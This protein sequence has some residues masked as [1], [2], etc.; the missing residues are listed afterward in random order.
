MNLNM[1]RHIF[2]LTTTA[3]LVVTGLLK[4]LSFTSHSVLLELSDPVFDPLRVKYVL[5]LAGSIEIILAVIIWHFRRNPISIV[6]LSTLVLCFIFYRAGLL[7]LGSTSPCNCLGAPAR[8]QIADPIT[9]NRAADIILAYWIVGIVI[10]IYKS[11]TRPKCLLTAILFTIVVLPHSVMASENTI[12]ITGQIEYTQYDEKG[13]T[14]TNRLRH[15][16]HYI[17]LLSLDTPAW[18]ITALYGTN[19]SR[20]DWRSDVFGYGSNVYDVLYDPSVP[21]Q[22][23][24]PGF[25][26]RGYYPSKE[27]FRITIPWLT[28]CS[29]RH[30][31]LNIPLPWKDDFTDPVASI[32]DSKITLA[33]GSLAFP[34]AISWII[35]SKKLRSC[36]NQETLKHEGL[37]Q[38]DRIARLID[39]STI[40][41]DGIVIGE[42]RVTDWTKARG[43]T[44]PLHFMLTAYAPYENVAS[45]QL[46]NNIVNISYAPTETMYRSLLFEGSTTQIFFTNTTVQPLSVPGILSVGDYRLFNRKLNIDYVQYACTDGKWKTNIDPQLLALLDIRIDVA[47]NKIRR[48]HARQYIIWLCMALSCVIPYVG[49]RMTKRLRTQKQQQSSRNNVL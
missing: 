44:I 42:Y 7:L 47:K 46:S 21:P 17:V 48:R 22:T 27:T 8:W 45:T 11:L 2:I 3:I 25:I 39:Y 6:V 34:E 41:R 24:L 5:I 33:A 4:L 31:G 18:K 20:G 16:S 32:A 1:T 29:G 40:Y 26:T 12:Q 15:S 43:I 38:R 30:A 37:P 10:V 35:N 19:W 36:S 9:R 13:H 14:V 23:P 28:Y 49:Y